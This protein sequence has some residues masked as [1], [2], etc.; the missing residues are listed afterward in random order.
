MGRIETIKQKIL[1]LDAGSFQNLCDSYLCKKFGYQSIVSLGGKAGTQ[2]TTLGT[3]DTYFI[4]PNEGYILVEYTTQ[5]TGTFEKI[6]DDIKKCLDK[7][8]IGIPYNKISGIIYCH[9]SSN[10]TPSQDSELKKICEKVGINLTIIG[11]DAIAED[12]YLIYH[13]IARDFLGIPISTGQIQSYDE[14]IN[15]YNSNVMVAPIDTEFLFRK[16]EL[17]DI[18][19]AYN[20]VDV[21][22]LSGSAGNGKTRLALHYLK[23]YIGENNKKT[24]CIY[25]KSLPIYEDLK[26][27]LDKPGDYF[28]FI[29]D[30]NQLSGSLEHI[31]RYVNMK[32]SGY[33]VKILI[34]VRDYATQKVLNTVKKITYY[35]KV[36]VN[37]F[38]DKEIRELLKV[39]FGIVNQNYQERILKISEGNPRIAILAGK[40]VCDSNHLK[41][42]TDVSQLYEN[43][44][45]S[46]VKDNELF[47]NRNLGITVGIIAFLGTIYLEKID[48]ILSI[49]EGK[50][51]NRDKFI[52]NIY[53]LHDQEIVDIYNDK[54]VRFSDQCLSNYLLKYVFFDKRLL[55]LSKMIKI[56]FFDYKDKT[57]FSVNTLISIF[58]NKELLNFVNKEIKLIWK[59]L[60]IE[61]STI[62]YEFVKAFFPI[63]PTETLLIL[64]NEI[65]SDKSIIFEYNNIDVEKEK[66]NHYVNNYII[67]ILGRFAYINDFSTACELF[68]E[69]YLKRPDL[70]MEFYHAVNMYF[71]IDK[72]SIY[73]DF[74]TQITLFE[75]IIEY[76]N[77]WKQ[78]Q[79]VM[80]F[81][82]IVKEFLKVHF[83]PVEGRKNNE[84]IMY[85][86]PLMMSKGV[87]KYRKLIW[88]SL[89]SLSKI[90]KYKEEV[91]KILYSYGNGIHDRSIPVVKFD[92]VYIESI[93]NLNFSKDK[94]KNCLVVR[95]IEQV[96]RSIGV[97]DGSTFSEY[98]KGEKFKIYCILEGSYYKVDNYE[99]NK[100]QKKQSIDNYISNC[101]WEMFK[102]LIDVC[103]EIFGEDNYSSWNIK[104]GLVIVFDAVFS[105]KDWYI[106]AVKYY[107]KKNTPYNLYPEDII[108]KLFVLLL[109][110]EVYKIIVDEEYSQRND[111]LYAYYHELPTNLI[112]KKHLKGLYDFLK[113]TSDKKD[114]LQSIRGVDFLEKY[115]VIN[116]QAFLEGC[117]IILKK[118]EYSLHVVNNYFYLLFN[119]YRN[120]PKE[121]ISKF[122]NNLDLLEE[123]YCTILSYDNN[124]DHDGKFLKDI[125]LSKPSV[126]YKYIDYLINKNKGAFKDNYKRD[127][128][129]F[130]LKDFIEIYNEIFEQMIK[131]CKFPEFTVVYFLESLL[132]NNPDKPELVGKQHEW[133]S[134]C[135]KSFSKDKIKMKYL[136]SAIS[137]L[138]IKRKE[139]YV[140]M[141]LE[142]NT[143]FEDFQEIPLTP[144]SYSYSDSAVPIYSAW[145]EFLESLVSKFV[146]LKW[147][148]HKNYIEEEISF[149]KVRIESEEIN[150]ILRG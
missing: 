124:I 102:K 100:K 77:D 61:K 104:E 70:F 34:T 132:S 126:L 66:N 141:F 137:N 21:V 16:K 78:E 73:N 146:G 130:E 139:E 6:S 47:S 40:L 116:E 71:R 32:Q 105:K 56:C 115:K 8:K 36:N 87:E 103:S 64:K 31:I 33:N 93:L 91:G 1:Q 83:S 80:F 131:N 118:R 25:S 136:F 86:I 96:F 43:Y 84:L 133:I 85:N 27:F 22:I 54:V 18:E 67:E 112:T 135:I 28:L 111:W 52:E 142:N 114:T 113:D 59:E 99:E 37:A 127:Q 129:F 125:Y 5:L 145:I 68:L 79:I 41:S 26:L 109:D 29:D 57:I 89:I 7:E 63:N 82:Q 30:A 23:N 46:I 20:K 12:I 69:Y 11:I 117:K 9:T 53:M 42:I 128:I 38:S 15:D 4:T 148:K 110:S 45:G 107:I 81:L 108:K 74:Y 13:S 35:E 144:S 17:Q 140:L 95:R 49:L 39:T 149:L 150:R 90:E 2:K 106:D 75:K 101:D 72:N 48:I 123:I 134:Q 3:P 76:S 65:E 55:S 44:Y 121:V 120:K 143:S 94:L 119:Y 14:F 97:S 60:S 147:I 88:E 10:I 50:G 24:Y 92:L 98:F 62:F 138:E 19:E 51:I 122:N 58:R